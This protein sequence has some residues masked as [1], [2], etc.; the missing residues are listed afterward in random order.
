MDYINECN[1]IFT[2]SDGMR[3]RMTFNDLPESIREELKIYF[4]E[5]EDLRAED[6]ALY[7]SEYITRE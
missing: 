5:L 6:K 4:R 3:E 2:W 1:T 7:D